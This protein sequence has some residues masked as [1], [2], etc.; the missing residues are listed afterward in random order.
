MAGGPARRMDE[1]I[2][3]EDYAEGVAAFMEKRKPVWRHR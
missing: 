3:L 1:S 2:A